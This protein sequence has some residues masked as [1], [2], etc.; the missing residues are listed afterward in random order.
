MRITW[1]TRSFLDYRIPVFKEIDRLCGN[2][3]T[4]LY[5]EDV[6]PKRCKDKLKV[7]L[8]DRSIGLSGE[9]R[10]TGKKSQ[11]LSS[12]HKKRLR[13]PIQP[14]LC[15]QIIKSNPD[16]MLSDGFFQWTYAPLLL[17]FWKK[18]PL[19]MLYEG[20][21]HTERST[22]KIRTLYRKCVS[23]Y[24]DRISCNGTLSSEYVQSLGYSESKI[25]IGNMAAD[26]G[27]L[28]N[29]LTQY[30]EKEALKLKTKYKLNLQ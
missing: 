23:H 15:K 16:I 3:L 8:G 11:P 6:V 28:Q 21:K 12:I 17:R 26:T 9:I 30:S 25:S 4:V 1:V 19:L 14:G 10:L 13:I 29:S 20:T 24:I 22:G 27:T 5:S 18:I 2:Q 7:I